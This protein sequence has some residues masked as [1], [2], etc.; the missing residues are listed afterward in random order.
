MEF[1]DMFVCILYAAG[2]AGKGLLGPWHDSM[3]TSSLAG[4]TPAEAAYLEV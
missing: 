1:C 3:L 2:P 4:G